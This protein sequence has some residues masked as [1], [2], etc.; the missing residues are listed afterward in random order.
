MGHISVTMQTSLLSK[1]F[2]PVEGVSRGDLIFYRFF[3]RITDQMRR[4]LQ[5]YKETIEASPA[6]FLFVFFQQSHGFVPCSK[7]N[8]NLPRLR[9]RSNIRHKVRSIVLLRRSHP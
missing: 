5:S 7:L 8:G 3:T 6:N 1:F 2:A 9:S 4:R